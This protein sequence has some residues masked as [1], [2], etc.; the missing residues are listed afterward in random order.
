MKIFLFCKIPL[1]HEEIKYAESLFRHYCTIVKGCHFEG[2]L[3]EKNIV[4]DVKI[5]MKICD[6]QNPEI[7]VKSENDQFLILQDIDGRADLFVISHILRRMLISLDNDWRVI[8]IGYSYFDDTTIDDH[9]G[10][11]YGGGLLLI[12][13]DGIETST[14]YQL[15]TM[16]P[17]REKVNLVILKDED[18]EAD[19]VMTDRPDRL[20]IVVTL[21][22][23]KKIR[24]YFLFNGYKGKVVLNDILHIAKDRFDSIKVYIREFLNR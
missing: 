8:K 22:E 6:K 3:E 14:T 19:I 15:E 24:D 12:S 2:V 13:K 20:G 10:S 21:R 1:K 18:N 7:F 23:D 5:L 4:R 11:A 16:Y 9:Y 17:Y